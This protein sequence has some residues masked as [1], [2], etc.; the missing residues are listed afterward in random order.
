MKELMEELHNKSSCTLQ[1]HTRQ[2]YRI[3]SYNQYFFFFFLQ[4]SSFTL[5]S[6]ILLQNFSSMWLARHFLGAHSENTIWIC[7]NLYLM[8]YLF[9]FKVRF[10]FPQ[11][12]PAHLFFFFLFPQLPVAQWLAWQLCC[13]SLGWASCRNWAN[14]LWEEAKSQN[15]NATTHRQPVQDENVRS[16]IY[17]TLGDKE[18]HS[19]LVVIFVTSFHSSSSYGCSN[20]SSRF[21]FPCI[22]QF[23]A[24]VVL[25]A[26]HILSEHISGIGGHY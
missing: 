26:P 5:T 21:S 8:D 6:S 16:T 9:Y 7:L 4:N 2:M 20:I 12:S 23:V 17:V 24:F 11:F 1:K 10:F 25:I 19:V 13:Y 15:T 3:Q 18:K 14:S 22:F